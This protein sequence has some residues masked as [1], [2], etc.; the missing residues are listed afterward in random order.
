[1]SMESLVRALST[2]APKLCFLAAV[3]VAV[4]LAAENIRSNPVAIDEYAHVP[5]GVSYWDFGRHYLYRENPPLVRLLTSLPVWL[6]RPKIS[7][8]GA[9]ASIRSEWQVGRDFIGANGS[10]HQFLFNEAR[11]VS[12]FLAVSCA[13]L[14]Y[15]WAEQGYGSGPAAVLACLW[16]LYPT[17]IAH[18]AIASVDVGACFFG[19]LA[20]YLFWRFLQSPGWRT[21]IVAAVGLG[22]AE[23]SKFTMLFLYPALGLICV[24]FRVIGRAT[25]DG[26]GFR[27][28]PPCLQ[29]VVAFAL[30][31]VVLNAIYAFDRVGRPLGSF[32][33]KS[34]V[35]SGR[36]T[37][38]PDDVAWGNRFRGTWLSRF[39]VFLPEDYV[40]GLDSQKWEEEIGFHRPAPGGGLV[41]GGAWYSP[42]STL[43][44]KLPLGTLALI[45]G[46]VIAAVAGVRHLCYQVVYLSII[47]AAFC[48]V[49]MPQ[50]GLNWAARYSL[51]VFPFLVLLIGQPI[52]AAW[53][54]RVWR[55]LILAS[56]GWN[57]LAVLLAR[58][59]FF[60]YG[61]ELIG[62][63]EGAR[64]F[65]AGG[66]LDW[67]QDLYRLA[68]WRVEHP[69]FRPMAILY[70]GVL[71]PASL[72]LNDSRVPDAF[73]D[74][75]PEDEPNSNPE[76]HL[77]LAISANLLLGAPAEVILESG[78]AT[79]AC[80]NPRLLNFEGAFA[81]VG[82]TIYLFE[83]VPSLQE[84]R[85]ARPI[86]F[87]QLHSCLREVPSSMRKAKM[88]L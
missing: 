77:Y 63:N 25:G 12:L 43:A 28:R 7:Y 82:M 60:S 61:N 88:I 23:G 84:A 52:Q 87:E 54:H 69:E 13:Y 11:C 29:V 39:P 26:R 36:P 47:V 46:S 72:G 22:M 15:V 44:F 20:A 48:L 57:L 30:S 2:I 71:N 76:P 33:F 85:T 70:Y 67:G 10:R 74:T 45:L 59:H 37:A 27:Y 5:A 14:I 6:S 66:D 24:V 51:P 62:G 32:H 1:M 68:R 8:R 55:W 19:L 80:I 79:L 16:L 31:V 86:L 75:T 81:R 18:A 40:L 42:L 73:L 3:F 83:V 49:L 78:R 58:P 21:T 35:L 38:D 53:K 17:V 64:R 4:A 65:F 56:V 9:D 34:V 50:T 41:R